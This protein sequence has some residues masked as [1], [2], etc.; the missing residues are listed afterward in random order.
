M[1]FLDNNGLEYYTTKVIKKISDIVNA[2]QETDPTVPSYVK[3]IT[4]NEIAKWN[5]MRNIYASTSA[6]TTSDGVDGDIWI[7][8]EE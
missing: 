6:P 4:E 2:K 3:N 1:Q 5:T 7:I 8:Y